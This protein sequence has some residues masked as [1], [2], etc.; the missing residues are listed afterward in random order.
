MTAQSGNEQFTQALN[1]R[2]QASQ[3]GL[4]QL[5]FR[6]NRELENLQAQGLPRLIE[7]RGL[8]LGLQ[9]FMDRR[10]QLMQLLAVSA[11]TSGVVPGQFSESMGGNVGI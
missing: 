2:M 8:E 5:G 9:E 1:R 3:Q 4:S 10:Q 7:Q 6:F 11:Q